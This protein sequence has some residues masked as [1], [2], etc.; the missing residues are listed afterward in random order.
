MSA[1][2]STEGN[3]ISSSKKW[4]VL[5]NKIFDFLKCVFLVSD[6]HFFILEINLMTYKESCNALVCKRGKYITLYIAEKVFKLI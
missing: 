5:T 6:D 4:T 1:S 3:R 2:L